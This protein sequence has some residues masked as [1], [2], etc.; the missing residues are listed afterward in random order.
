MRTLREAR[1]L[2]PQLFNDLHD[3]TPRRWRVSVADNGY[4]LDAIVTVLSDLAS[5][6]TRLVLLSCV[7]MQMLFGVQLE[8]LGL[9]WRPSLSWVGKFFRNLNNSY[10]AIGKPN[11]EVMS[12]YERADAT[13]NLR[14]KICWLMRQHNLPPDRVW[15]IDGIALKMLGSS[16]RGWS[17]R[18]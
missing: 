2:A 15:N 1:L 12:E 6:V 5:R 10:K 9:T 8:K 14:E 3:D 16:K 4:R 18:G 11:H 7:V 17:R 13:D